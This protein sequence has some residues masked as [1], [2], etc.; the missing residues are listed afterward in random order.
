MR[1]AQYVFVLMS[2]VA[3]LFVMFAF[4]A[5]VID[6][7]ISRS[8]TPTTSHVQQAPGGQDLDGLQQYLT[9]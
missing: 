2:Q 7:P 5:K 8:G 3:L 4:G 6:I 9:R 1:T